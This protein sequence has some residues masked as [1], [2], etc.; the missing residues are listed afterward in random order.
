M[1]MTEQTKIMNWMKRPEA[2]HFSATLLNVRVTPARLH[3]HAKHFLL[4]ETVAPLW[5]TDT[6][7]PITLQGMKRVIP[8]SLTSSWGA[9]GW[10]IATTH[11]ASTQPHCPSR[12][13]RRLVS[14]TMR[15]DQKGDPPHSEEPKKK[16]KVKEM[17]W[18]DAPTSSSP[19]LS[20]ITRPCAES[21][22]LCSEG[23]G[24]HWEA[25]H[26]ETQW[27]TETKWKRTSRG[28]K[29]ALPSH[30]LLFFSSLTWLPGQPG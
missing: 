14:G 25:F 3:L 12:A 20:C 28:A 23:G 21:C 17:A 13:E 5:H 9:G 27:M 26:A 15:G 4:E 19:L 1:M 8:E 6:H 30:D 22:P 11:F 16:R 29:D 10:G 18:R 24:K 7:S 2:T